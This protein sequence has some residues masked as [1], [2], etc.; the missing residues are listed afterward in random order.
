MQG[1]RE[2]GLAFPILGK[3]CYSDESKSQGKG[4]WRYCIEILFRTLNH[5]EESDIEVSWSAALME[6]STSLMYAGNTRWRTKQIP[7][8]YGE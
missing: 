1:I 6:T 5:D 2:G 3:L 7:G 8:T 4:Q